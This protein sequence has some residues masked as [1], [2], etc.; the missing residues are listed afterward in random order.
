MEIPNVTNIWEDHLANALRYFRGYRELS[1]YALKNISVLK[2]PPVRS[3]FFKQV[4]FTGIEA[5]S[6]VAAIGMLIGI[7]IITQVVNIVGSN[8]VL[9]G[10]ILAW[11]VV[12]E[13]GP[14]L[15]SIIII[16]RS[17]T[18]I[19][20]EL[21]AMKVNREADSLRIMGIDPKDYLIVPRIIGITVSVFILTF[22]F[23]I[24]AVAGGLAFI[25]I[26]KGIP[27]FQHLKGI[28]SVLSFFEIA[29]SLL[30]SL[31]F[32]FII[33]VIACYQGFSVRSSITEIPQA[34]T[35]A[36]MQ[37]LFL[38]IHIRRDNNTCVV[39]MI[40]LENID[41]EYFGH[42]SMEVKAGSVCKV[43]TKSDSL[44]DLLMD[45]MLGMKKPPSGRVS[46]FGMD[47]YSISG[48][49][50]IKL[51]KK[52]GVVPEDGGLI[53]NLKIWENIVLPFWYHNRSLPPD[54]E[55]RVLRITSGMGIDAS[56]LKELSGKLPGPLPDQVK[57]LIG[58]VRTM[59]VG[60]ELVI[61]GSIF[62]G[63]A[64]KTAE[65]LM[66]MTQAFHSERPDRTSVYI[67]SDPLSVLGIE[68]EQTIEIGN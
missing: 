58:L 44:K 13:L 25:S 22:Y 10:K 34:G 53:S 42:V 7:V 2:I 17:G 47:I 26:F 50:Y 27:F 6:K 49:E 28:S 62:E 67:T 20:S 37:S 40:K 24:T 61:Y 4:Y 31:V 29:V 9:T 43:F 8:A 33:S 23:Q 1:C 11:T 59:L 38:G 55:D 30:K 21:G 46:L 45:L 18:A 36:V 52:I 63:L 5:L 57:R 65:R 12:R 32:G 15:A 48:T 56:Y 3:V 66:D 19:A 39:R 14:L 54:I 51:F 68:A 64:Q 35:R 41:L 60:P 16:A